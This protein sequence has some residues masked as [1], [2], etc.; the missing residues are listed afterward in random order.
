MT[1]PTMFG[2]NGNSAMVGGEAGPEAILPLNNFYNYLDRKIS[3]INN[4]STNIDYNKL[5]DTIVT[6]VK[7]LGIN[8]DGNKVGS[9]LDKNSGEKIY[10]SERG[11]NV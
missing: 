1:N 9:I 10:L 11:L 5:A 6:A 2:M 4:S 3:E 8:L 7:N